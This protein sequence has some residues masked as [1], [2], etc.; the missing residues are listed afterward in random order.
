M[1]DK[2]RLSAKAMVSG[3]HFNLRKIGWEMG[4]SRINGTDLQ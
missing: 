1:M 2:D 4:V 3:G